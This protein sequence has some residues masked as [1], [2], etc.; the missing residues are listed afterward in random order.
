[1]IRTYKVRIFPTKEQEELIYKHIGCCRF[2]W[3][4]ALENEIKYYE[5]TKGYY[6]AFDLIKM[7]TPLKKQEKYSWL[8]EVSN[9]SLKVICRDLDKAYKQFFKNKSNY[10]KFKRKKNDRISYPVCQ[11]RFYF[12]KDFAQIQ[13]IG[14][15]EYKTN[16]QVPLGKDAKFYNPRISLI[17]NKWIL[18]VNY[19]CE[20]QTFDLT[21]KVI[22]ID[23]GVKELAVVAYGNKNNNDCLFFKNINKS[24]KMKKLQKKLKRLQ[25]KVSRKYVT[26]KSFEKTFNI[27]KTEKQIKELYYHIANIRKNYIHQTTHTLIGLLPYK[28]V[29]EDLNI[30]GM[31]KNKHLSKAISEQ[32]FYEFIR[33]MKYKCEEKGIEFIQVDRFFPSSKTCSSCGCIKSDL[34]LSDRTFICEHCGNVIDRDYNAA[35]NLM[36][37]AFNT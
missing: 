29:M 32:N 18:T 13:K 12:T 9:G 36:Q 37:Y 17:N 15:I 8:N 10:P 25:R 11:E 16:Y 3:N 2:I 5:K 19:E 27:L 28:I 35:I 20:N 26:N 14:K 21:D 22:G 1:M 34:K 31:M 24:T 6:S 30:S 4:W 23:L 7:L 33:Q